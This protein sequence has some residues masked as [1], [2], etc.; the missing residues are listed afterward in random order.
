MSL[1]DLRKMGLLKPENEW[2]SQLPHSPVSGIAATT[3]MLLAAAG[4]TGMAL[5]D[6]GRWTWIGLGAFAVA[7][8]FFVTLNIRSVHGDGLDTPPSETDDQS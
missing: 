4:C 6:G 5:G 3:W 8:V 2:T 1:S 7:L